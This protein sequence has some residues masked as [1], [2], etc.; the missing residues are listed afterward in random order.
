MNKLSEIIGTER[1]AMSDL[2]RKTGVCI[3][4]LSQ[5]KHGTRTPC[6]KTAAT[7]AAAAGV[8]VFTM[9]PEAHRYQ[10]AHEFNMI[11]GAQ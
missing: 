11:G 7:I 6:F 5:I 4:T 3:S 1:G 2:A 8:D 9:F 10:G